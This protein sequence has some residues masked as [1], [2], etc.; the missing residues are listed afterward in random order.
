MLE[1]AICFAATALSMVGL[2]GLLPFLR[3]EL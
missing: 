1:C 2:V 3:I